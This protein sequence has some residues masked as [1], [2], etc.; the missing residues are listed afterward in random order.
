MLVELGL[1]FPGL[2]VET[3]EEGVCEKG[4]VRLVRAERIPGRCGVVVE[5]MVTVKIMGACKLLLGRY[6]M[7]V[8]V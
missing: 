4:T 5:V 8:P 7:I 2:G 3:R 1:V 6:N